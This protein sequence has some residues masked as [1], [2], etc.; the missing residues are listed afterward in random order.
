MLVS[1]GDGWEEFLDRPD[2]SGVGWDD[3][4]GS[5]WSLADTNVGW[6]ELVVWLEMGCGGGIDS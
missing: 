5:E 3:K 1:V 4:D 6:F 2:E